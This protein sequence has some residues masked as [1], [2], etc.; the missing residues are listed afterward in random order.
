MGCHFLLQG[1]FLTQGSNPCPLHWQLDSLPLRHRGSPPLGKNKTT[2]RQP[3]LAIRVAR[4]KD[5]N[6]T[7]CWRGCRET[8][9]LLVGTHKGE[10]ILETVWQFL[11]ELNKQAT[12]YAPVTAFLDIQCRE[13]KAYGHKNNLYMKVHVSSI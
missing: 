10:G 5:S 8:G 12:A 13:M 4:K 6:T 3:C 2:M 11:K 7:T 9:S 1:I